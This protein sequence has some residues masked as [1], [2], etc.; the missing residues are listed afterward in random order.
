MP[1]NN[2]TKSLDAAVN[3]ISVRF[4]GGQTGGPHQKKRPISIEAIKTGSISLDNALGIG[5]FPIGKI[6]E[7]YGTPASGKTTLC[8]E[9]IANAQKDGKTCLLIDAE[10]TFDPAYAASI[11]VNID[12]LLISQPDDGNSIFT[13]AGLLIESGAIDLIIV[14]SVAAITPTQELE[15]EIGASGPFM[16]VSLMTE[17]LRH[18]KEKLKNS[19]CAVIFTNQIRYKLRQDLPAQE[20]TSGGNALKYFASVRI[21]MRILKTI[22]EDDVPVANQ[23]RVKV[24]KNNLR[25]PFAIS[26]F[27]IR[28]GQGIDQT[29]EIFEM[30][31][32]KNWIRF[33]GGE[34]HCKETYLGPTIETAIAR[35]DQET[36]LRNIIAKHL[37]NTD[38]PE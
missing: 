33:N 29:R 2:S 28:F 36:Y 14:D 21:D 4:G 7:I 1:Y 10:N 18:L 19:H 3:R 6:T 25:P 38:H 23:V 32:E 27:H 13:I 15:N 22:T 9:T 24:A 26:K 16:Q 11:G 35:L 17:G 37:G 20:T 5:G 30:A 8:L 34:Y 31:K 12:T